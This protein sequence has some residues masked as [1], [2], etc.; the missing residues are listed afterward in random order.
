MRSLLGGAELAQVELL[1]AL[2]SQR[3][4]V[5]EAETGGGVG[6]GG[7]GGTGTGDR[8]GWTAAVC[9]DTKQQLAIRGW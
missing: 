9:R 2:G 6:S 4:L 1:T 8:T 3:G 5:T 7:G